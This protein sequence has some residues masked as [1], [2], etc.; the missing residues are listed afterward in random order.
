MLQ[1]FLCK[2]FLGY[3]KLNFFVYFDGKIN[4]IYMFFQ[5]LETITFLISY[6]F[7]FEFIG[8]ILLFHIVS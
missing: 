8:N 7:L 1:K 6:F 5:S 3:L 2:H 4:F